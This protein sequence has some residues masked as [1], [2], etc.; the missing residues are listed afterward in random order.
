MFFR[1]LINYNHRQGQAKEFVNWT[2]VFRHEDFFYGL[3]MTQGYQTG[4]L[5]IIPR[6]LKPGWP[7]RFSPFPFLDLTLWVWGLGLDLGLA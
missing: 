4:P 1:N 3:R 7:I 5:S 2:M 6:L